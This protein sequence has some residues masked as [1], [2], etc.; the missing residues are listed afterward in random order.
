MLQNHKN[1]ACLSS[2]VL[3]SL[4]CVQILEK[5]AQAC[6]F[7]TSP[8]RTSGPGFHFHFHSGTWQLAL[9]Y[10]QGQ[11]ILPLRDRANIH[12][13]IWQSPIQ[14]HSTLPLKDL[15][16]FHSGIWHLSN[17]GPGTQP[18]REVSLVHQ[19]TWHLSIQGPGTLSLRY[20]ALIHPGTWAS[21]TLP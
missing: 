14:R 6:D 11:G 10:T 19:G 12:S 3:K 16:L 2:F 9:F 1:S 13:G 21:S 8:F 7:T 20:L 17:K 15:E 18:P 4:N 5:F